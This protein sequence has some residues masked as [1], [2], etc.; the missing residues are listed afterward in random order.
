MY[1]FEI[2]LLLGLI[3]SDLFAGSQLEANK[4]A[5]NIQVYTT[6]ILNMIVWIDCVGTLVQDLLDFILN[7]MCVLFTDLLIL[8]GWC[9]PV[10]LFV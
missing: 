4:K 6:N 1:Q 8:H 2:W 10:T 5:M 7:L 3:F 9:T